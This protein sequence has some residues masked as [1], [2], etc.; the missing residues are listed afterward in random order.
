MVSFL[1]YFSK[2]FSF[3]LPCLISILYTYY[4]QYYVANAQQIMICWF[5]K[6]I[7]YFIPIFI[8]KRFKYQQP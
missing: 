7:N 2:S 1:I 4:S 8:R 5:Y 3:L 6:S